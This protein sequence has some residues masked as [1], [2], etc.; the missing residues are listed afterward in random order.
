MMTQIIWIVIAIAYLVLAIA[1]YWTSGILTHFWSQL[2]V[3]WSPE[4]LRNLIEAY[5]TR[6]WKGIFRPIGFLLAAIFAMMMFLLM[7]LFFLLL[8]IVLSPRAVYQTLR[9]MV[10]GGKPPGPQHPAPAS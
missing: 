5:P 1:W 10:G 9:R 8:F 4:I 3:S 6:K 2:I 7:M